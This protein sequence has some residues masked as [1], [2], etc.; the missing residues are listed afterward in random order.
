MKVK[1]IAPKKLFHPVLPYPVKRKN[2][3][4]LLFPLCRTCAE[5]SSYLLNSCRHEGDE[6]GW[7]G[8]YTTMEV[9]EAMRSGYRL[10]K[11]Y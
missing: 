6:R 1:M 3:T 10:D 9:Y 5:Q 2:E 11:V 4:K 7:V 8:T